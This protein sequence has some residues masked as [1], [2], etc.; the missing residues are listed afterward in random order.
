MKHYLLIFLSFLFIALSSCSP[1]PQIYFQGLNRSDIGHKI[2]NYSPLT[3]QPGD[4]LGL[5]VKS[6]N[7]E[8][9]AIFESG[10]SS[11]SSGSATSG[12]GGGGGS[13]AGY[14]VDQKGEIQLPLVHN[15]KLSGLTLAEAQNV[16]Q[17]AITPYLK[18][19][20]VALN[21]LN[22]KISILGDV[23]HPGV[24]PINSDHI[25]MPEA[26]SLAGDL[27]I[28]GK[29]ENILLIREINGERKFVNIDIGSDKLFDSPYYY[30]KNNDILYIEPTKEKYIAV[31]SASRT[32][33]LVLSMI[34]I[35]LIILEV[36]KSY[37]L[38]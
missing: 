18:E 16:I 27:T 10:G 30:L 9:S 34:S 37:K 3:I 8:G 32:V 26:L 21:L 12:G 17:Q 31:S 38:F 29:I 28:S 11:S 13:L 1:K 22:F 4:V 33:P 35:L 6:L 20:I 14:K 15:I 25:S 7:P 36:N 24:F 2:E 23:S 19:P 5:S